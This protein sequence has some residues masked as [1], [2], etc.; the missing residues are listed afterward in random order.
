MEVEG[1]AM[2][3]RRPVAVCQARSIL[4]LLIPFWW[5]FG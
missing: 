4:A 5:R 2:P 1:V 3:K